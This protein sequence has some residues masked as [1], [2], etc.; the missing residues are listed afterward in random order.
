MPQSIWVEEFLGC[1]IGRNRFK[2]DLA[3]VDQLF[4]DR[5]NVIVEQARSWA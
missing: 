4:Q 3:I 5:F 1:D 2:H